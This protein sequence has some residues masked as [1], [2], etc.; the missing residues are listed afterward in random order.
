M[1]TAYHQKSSKREFVA[2]KGYGTVHHTAPE[3]RHDCGSGG[4]LRGRPGL[5]DAQYLELWDKGQYLH[6]IIYSTVNP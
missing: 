5:P 3:D 2:T 6:M 4:T 1:W